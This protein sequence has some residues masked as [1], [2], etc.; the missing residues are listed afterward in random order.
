MVGNDVE[1]VR[2]DVVDRCFN[3]CSVGRWSETFSFDLESPG[4]FGYV[5]I[6]VSPE[7]P[8]GFC[9]KMVGNQSQSGHLQNLTPV[10]ILVSPEIPSG[11]CWKM[12]GNV[13]AIDHCTA[14]TEFQSLSHQRSLRDSVGRRSET[15]TIG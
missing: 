4:A 7:I 15:I 3:P 5:S 6:L 1:Y 8:S 2:K 11:F 13:V 10:S 9:W 12:V 14:D